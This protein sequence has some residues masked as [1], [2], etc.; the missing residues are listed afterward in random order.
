[1]ATMAPAAPLLLGGPPGWIAFG[2]VGLATLGGGYLI[3]EN[4]RSK[5]ESGPA[6]GA[7]TDTGRKSCDRPWSV[8]IHAQGNVIGGRGSATLGAP[9]ILKTTAPVTVAEGLALSASTFALLSRGQAKALASAQMQAN[10]W[11]SQR[12]PGGYLGQK[13]FYG[14]GGQRGNDRFDVDSYGC[15][16]NFIV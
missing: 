5:T 11:I 14:V 1:M 7:Q 16:N 13:S 10:K 6:T 15:S 9:P 12:P 2:L 3:Y 4:S 8:R